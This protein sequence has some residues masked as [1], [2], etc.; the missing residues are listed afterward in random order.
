[1]PRRVRVPAQALGADQDDHPEDR[2]D[3]QRNQRRPRDTPRAR[4]IELIS[5]P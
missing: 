3:H 1:M 4:K 2:D 5:S